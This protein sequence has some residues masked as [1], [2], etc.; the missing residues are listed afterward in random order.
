MDCEMVGVGTGNTS[1][2]AHVCIVNSF[3]A[4]VSSLLSLSVAASL[5]S[6]RGSRRARASTSLAHTAPHRS[7]KESSSAPVPLPPHFS[8]TP[9]CYAWTQHNNRQRCVRVIRQAHGHNYG[10][11]NPRVRDQTVGPEGPFFFRL[12]CSIH[13]F[14]LLSSSFFVSV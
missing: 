10:L 13:R 14:S 2:L 4:S 12:F 7:Q 1:A 5:F 11:P 9:V 8:L 3:G 6:P